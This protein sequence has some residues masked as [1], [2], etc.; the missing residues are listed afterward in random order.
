ME[1]VILSGGKGTRL[2][3]LTYT[4]PKPL[5][6]VANRPMVEHILDRLPAEVDRALVASGYMIEQIETWAATHDHRVDLQVIDEPEPLGTGGAIA[7]LADHLTG[8]FLCFNGDVLSTAP[9][10]HMI[11]QRREAEAMGVLSLWQVDDPSPFGVVDLDGDRITRFVEKPSPG[12]APT[13][14]INAGTYCFSQ[15]ILD[16]IPTG[17]KVSLE[18]EVFPQ[19]L[20]EGHNL[21]GQPFKGHWVDCGRPEVYLKA[22]EILLDGRIELG[23]DARMDGTWTGWACLGD[24]A[25]VEEGAELT[26]SVLLEGAR[27]GTGA[28]LED[29]VVGAGADIGAEAHLEGCV[30][31]DGETLPPG[32]EKKEER[33]GGPE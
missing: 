30:I 17:R 32:T 10:Q 26:R 29:T 13:R 18:R 3:P 22:H 19:L 6:P 25:V 5:L 20:D 7:N 8:D 24:G 14:L 11:D 23:D 28:H 1:A 4:R 31:G 2:R 12:E 27:V 21:L 33:I 9:L 15:E 16:H